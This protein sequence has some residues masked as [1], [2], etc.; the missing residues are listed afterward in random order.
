[1]EEAQLCTTTRSCVMVS[2]DKRATWHTAKATQ[3]CQTFLEPRELR[4]VVQKM[5]C[6]ILCPYNAAYF[7]FYSRRGF[8][9]PASGLVVEEVFSLCWIE[10]CL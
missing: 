8:L 7:K 10:T 3:S 5:C 9:A 1:M 6:E 2:S 4:N